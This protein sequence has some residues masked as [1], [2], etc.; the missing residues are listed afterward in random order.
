M[1]TPCLSPLNSLF[2]FLPRSKLHLSLYD[3]T[4]QWQREGRNNNNNNNN[5]NDNDN[6]NDNNNNNK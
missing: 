3:P 5:D 4:K 1:P 6:D 2:V